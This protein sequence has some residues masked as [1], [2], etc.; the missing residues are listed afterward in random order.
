MTRKKTRFTPEMITY[1]EQAGAIAANMGAFS[2][3]VAL[4]HRPEVAANPF[5]HLH[6]LDA[7]GIYDDKIWEFFKYVC[8]G[9]MLKMVAVLQAHQLDIVTQETIESCI[10]ALQVLPK[11]DEIFLAEPT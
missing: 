2:M 9:D 7:L 1:D 4:G 3:L 10:E 11:L 8:G 5:A 6:Q